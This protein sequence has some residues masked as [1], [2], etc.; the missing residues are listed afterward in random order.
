MP[1]DVIVLGAGGHARVVIDGLRR[2]GFSVAG[3]CAP[4]L[5]PGQ[6]GPLGVT[7]LGNDD[8][9]ARMDK[10]SHLLANG[11]GSVGDV[12]IRRTVFERMTADGWRFATLIHP[13][14]TVGDQCNLAEGAQIMAGAVLQCGVHVGRNT[15]V[16]SSASIDHDCRIGDH[17]HVAPGA[18]LSG[19]V[20][21]GA[22]SHLGTGAIVIHGNSIG[23]DV[24]IGA[25]AVVTR[26]VASGTR[27]T[28][29]ARY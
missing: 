16:N 15:I 24:L 20:S 29:G 28:A 19:N 3:I 6:P 5:K 7:V 25:G 9:L 23:D 10:H 11:I 12:T 8:A 21:V 13:A 17:V 26:A 4:E 2:A 14:A 18:V 22:R 1:A 27:V